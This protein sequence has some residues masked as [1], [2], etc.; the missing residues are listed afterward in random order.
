MVLACKVTTQGVVPS[1][2]TVNTKTFMSATTNCVPCC[3]TPQ[4][5]NTP[6]SQGLDGT[7]GTNGINAFAIVGGGG[8]VVPAIGS[9]VAATVDDTSWMVPGQVLI[10]TG[11]AN[12][13]VSGTPP[14]ATSVTLEFLGYPGDVNA[15]TTIAAGALLSPAGLRGGSTL[16]VRAS[17]VS[18][19][20]TA[21]D[22]VLLLTADAKTATL[23]TA[24][25]ITGKVYTVKQTVATSGTVATTGQT[26]QAWDGRETAPAG[27]NSSTVRQ[28]TH[29][30]RNI[31]S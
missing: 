20:L 31:N 5:T 22:D 14:S 30:P 24:V 6:G 7:D 17:A 29:Y 28:H 15:G 3:S 10:A 26:T 9:T 23:P 1:Q 18:T 13:L 27:A 12:F 8:F 25:A 16:A 4:V 2:Q 19:A 21:F 11:P